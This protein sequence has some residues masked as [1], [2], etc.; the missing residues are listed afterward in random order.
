VEIHGNAQNSSP[1]PLLSADWEMLK[2]ALQ[3]LVV[4]VTTPLSREMYNMHTPSYPFKES[5]REL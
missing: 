3:V 1:F 4:F 2:S 5:K